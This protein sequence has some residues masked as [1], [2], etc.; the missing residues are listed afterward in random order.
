MKIVLINGSPK[1][2]GGESECILN[3]L[4][5]RLSDSAASVAVCSVIK[6]SREE[7][8]GALQ[9]CDALVFAFPLYVDALPSHLLA[10]LDETQA[11]IASRA[12]HATVYALVN[13]GFYEARQNAIALDMMRNFCE[14]A[15][16]AWGYGVGIGAGG[17]IGIAPIGRGPMKNLGRALD[18][19]AGDI[20]GLRSAENAAVNSNPAEAGE[21]S[22]SAFQPFAKSANGDRRVFVE[23]NF[24][25]FLYIW[26]AHWSWRAG[27]KKNRVKL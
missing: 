12:P 25:R 7:I 3:A 15:G 2:S 22:H 9:G 27:A 13:N 14:R 5:T 18:R 23:P 11:D 24:P 8:L 21:F 17:M 1:S 4:R 10:F 20:R 19:L 16:L 26:A 6:Q